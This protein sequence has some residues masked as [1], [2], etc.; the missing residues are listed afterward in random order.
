MHRALG[1]TVVKGMPRGL[2]INCRM[3]P[4]W[5]QMQFL[6]KGVDPVNKTLPESLGIEIAEHSIERVVRGNPV[7]QCQ[8][9]LEKIVA[10]FAVSLDLF[11]RFGTTDNGA[12]GDADNVKEKMAVAANDAMIGK[13]LEV[14]HEGN[15]NAW[16]GFSVYIS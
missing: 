1:R 3:P 11:P 4:H 12:N 13:R 16:L 2:A 5:S 8:N 6:A 10:I 7:G 14:L 15:G 9:R